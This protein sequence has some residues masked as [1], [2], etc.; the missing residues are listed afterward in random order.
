MGTRLAIKFPR[1]ASDLPGFIH[2]VRNFAEDLARDLDRARLGE[3]ENMDEAELQVFVLIPASRLF[4]E[5]A[6]A[7]R[8]QAKRHNLIEGASFERMP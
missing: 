2:R 3:V 5:A 4:G 1:P 6:T 7:A 8:A